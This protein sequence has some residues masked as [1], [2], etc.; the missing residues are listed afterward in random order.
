MLR[1]LLAHNPSVALVFEEP[2]G[3]ADAEH[4]RGQGVAGAA[5]L[6]LQRAEVH[7]ARRSPRHGVGRART[8]PSSSPWP[9]PASASRRRTRR[10]S[11]R[12]SPRST[13]PGRS[14]SRGRAWACRCRASWPS[15]SAGRVT[16]RSAAGRWDR[17]FLCIVPRVYRGAARGRRSR[18]RSARQ[19]D[20]TRLPVLVVEDNR[21]TLFIYE[22]YLKGSGFQVI[23]ARLAPGGAAVLKELRPVAVVL[24]ILLE[25]ESTWEL[26]AE[27]KRQPQTRDLAAV[28]GDDGGQPAQG[29]ALGADDFCVKP[30]DRAWLLDSS[31]P[32]SAGAAGESADHRRRRGVALP[33]QGPA[34]R[35]ALLTCWSRRTGPRGC[36]WRRE[37]GRGPS[38]STW[39][40]RA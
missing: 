39:T 18:P 3:L 21:E 10:P 30:V 40:C 28:G 5:Q 19:V 12:S 7:R 33:A 4:R 17:R 24:D 11:S 20:P 16:L 34:G 15:C 2:A 13:A 23:P 22:K 38:S 8:T 14:G 1:P 25:G 29:P 9:T 32:R 35:Y 31:R 37:S 6:H 36:C 26:I 27:L